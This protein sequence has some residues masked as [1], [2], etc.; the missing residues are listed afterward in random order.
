MMRII[1]FAL[2][3][4]LTVAFTGCTTESTTT[5]TQ[6]RTDSSTSHSQEK[7]KKTGETEPG[8]AMEKVD[9]SVTT[10]THR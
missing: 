8:P 1:S 7:L 3:V 10:S 4:V 9:A 5:T 2:G 6:T